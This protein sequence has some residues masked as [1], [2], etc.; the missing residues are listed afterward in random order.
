MTVIHKCENPT[1]GGPKKGPRS[2]ELSMPFP[3]HW[4]FC[5]SCRSVVLGEITNKIEDER[6]KAKVLYNKLLDE[7]PI[8]GY[9]MGKFHYDRFG[10]RL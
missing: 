7:H 4:N 5:D 3:I 1:C 10:S 6:D 2:Y 9:V 8:L